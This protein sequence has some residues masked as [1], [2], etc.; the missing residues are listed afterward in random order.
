MDIFAKTCIEK[1]IV[2]VSD[3]ED[4]REL[5]RKLALPLPVVV[6]RGE[7]EGDAG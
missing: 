2:A 7:G 3:E 1:S 6:G 4:V 5:G